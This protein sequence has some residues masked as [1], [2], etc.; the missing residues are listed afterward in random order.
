MKKRLTY[1][2]RRTRQQDRQGLLLICVS[3]AAYTFY[4]YTQVGM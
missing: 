1:R 2:Q 3:L 4:V